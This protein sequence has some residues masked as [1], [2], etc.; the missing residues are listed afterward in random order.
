MI[1]HS[2]CN[3]SLTVDSLLMINVYIK[4]TTRIVIIIVSVVQNNAPEFY[5]KF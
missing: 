3:S 1:T 2:V 5:I 4:S